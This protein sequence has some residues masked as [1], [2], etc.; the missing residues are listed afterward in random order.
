MA[1]GLRSIHFDA[2]RLN[3]VL[4][5]AERPDFRR[6]DDVDAV[7]DLPAAL[8][9]RELMAAY[10]GAHVILTVR[11]IDSWWRSIAFHFNTANPIPE[12]PRLL[13]RLSAKF[14]LPWR[15]S[16]HDVFRRNLRNHAYGT[17][18]AREF[19]YKRR[20]AQH[21]RA[22]VAETPR[23]RLLVMDIPAGDGWDK[24]CPFL[25]VQPPDMPFPHFAGSARVPAAIA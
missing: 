15:E 13:H 21:N 7:V 18:V 17:P 4:A 20:F 11:D 12:H 1:L 19:L 6:Y 14:G 25:G 22:V 23:E 24:L 3:D 5:G 8:F 10:P 9:Y 16:A 2:V